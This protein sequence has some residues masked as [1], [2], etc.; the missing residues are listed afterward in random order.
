MN[1]AVIVVFLLL[2]VTMSLLSQ[3]AANHSQQ[4][5]SSFGTEEAPGEP[6]VERPVPIPDA[7]MRSL[8]MDNDVKGCLSYNPLAPGQLQSSW[9]SASEIHLN[10][11]LER[12]LVILPSNSTHEPNY[13]CFHSASGIGWFWI[14]RRIGERY[15]LV[16]KAAGNGL[17]IL[18]TRANGCRKIQTASNSQ[19]GRY[20]T[21]V[22]FCFDGKL[23]REC[24]TGTQRQ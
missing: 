9:F 14:Y 13:E 11:A 21:T 20:V 10:G 2:V 1:R 3:I 23:Y 24:R 7:V 12:D 8:E 4:Q 16:L 5:Q 18:K 22:T 15:Q 19:A 6:L 17:E